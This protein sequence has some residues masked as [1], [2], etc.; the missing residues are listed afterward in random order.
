MSSG[1]DRSRDRLPVNIPLVGKGA[2]LSQQRLSEIGDAAPSPDRDLTG[3][4]IDPLDS[5]KL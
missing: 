3:L 5:D 1:G 2:A 4:R